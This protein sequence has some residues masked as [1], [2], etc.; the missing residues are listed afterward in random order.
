VAVRLRLAVRG[1]ITRLS[2]ER[3]TPDRSCKA[4]HRRHAQDK[5]CDG[6]WFERWGPWLVR[7]ALRDQLADSQAANLKLID[8]EPINSAVGKGKALDGQAPDGQCT[9]SECA[10]PTTAKP[11]AARASA[12]LGAGCRVGTKAILSHVVLARSG[13]LEKTGN[14]V[15]LGVMAK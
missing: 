15:G 7:T 5:T 4:D 11:V 6:G 9:D 3:R 14:D 2:R 12:T 10:L 1:V 8:G 13:V